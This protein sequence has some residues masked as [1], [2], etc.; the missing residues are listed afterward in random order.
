MSELVTMSDL[1]TW[2]QSCPPGVTIPAQWL[3]EFLKDAVRAPDIQPAG[4]PVVEELNW[5]EKLWIAPRETRMGVT[6]LCEAFGKSRDWVY[7]Y[8]SERAAARRI[9]GGKPADRL[10][11]RKLDGCLV[12]VV[13]EIREWIRG[14]E[15]LVVG[16]RGLWVIDGDM[17]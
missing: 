9:A 7:R 2:L 1:V 5:K 12:F 3:L 17:P 14:R 6:E 11:H 13:G 8:T 10:P 15:E 4:V 16:Q